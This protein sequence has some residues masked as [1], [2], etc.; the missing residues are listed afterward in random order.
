MVNRVDVDGSGR[1]V[2]TAGSAA[3]PARL[4]GLD[5]L[6]AVAALA[7][8]FHHV[9]FASG[10]TFD[11]PVGGLLARLDIG[12]PVFFALSGFLLFRPVAVSVIDGS[13]LRRVRDHLARRAL[14]IYPAFWVALLLITALTSESFRDLSAAATTAALV[15]IHW[16]GHVFGPMPQAWSLATEIAFYASLPVLARLIRPLVRA[17]GRSRSDRVVGLFACVAGL[18]L[19]SVFFRLWLH[20]LA[21]G[22][23]GA[24][25]LWLPSQIDYFAIGMGLAAA[26]AGWRPG[27]TGR[28]RLERWAAPA[29]WWWLAAA[30]LF[31]VT[32]E[33]LGLARGL[34]VANW[35]LE[36]LRQFCYGAVSFLLLFPLV[37]APR[38][39]PAAAR[40]APRSLVRRIASSR[41]LTGLGTISYSFYLWH[42]VFI[43]HPWPPARRAVD[44]VWD[45]TVRADW[46]DS[47]LGWTGAAGA[48][49]SRFA[50]LAAAALVPT[51]AVSAAS[52]FLV[53][54]AGLARARRISSPAAGAGPLESLVAGLR[55]QWREA[56]FRAQLAA[57]AVL[58]A[59][60]RFCYVLTA[61]RSETLDPDSVFPGDQFYYVLAGDALADGRGFVVPW[62]GVVGPAQEALAAPH[63]A[64]HP[65]L[66]ALAAALAGFLPGPPGSHVLEQRLTMAALGVVAVVLIGLLGRAVAGRAAGAAAAGLAAVHPG[67]WVNDG[68]VMSETLVAITTAGALWAAVRYRRAPSLRGMAELGAWLGAAVMTRSELALL[69]PL[70]VVPLVWACHRSRRRRLGRA[71]AAA[72]VAAALCA[73]WVTANLVRFSEPVLLS[74]N[75]GLTLA[76]ANNPQTYGGGAIGF[77]SL[78]HAQAVV[79]VSGLDQGEASAAYTEAAVE[80]ALD[81]SERWPA[82]LAARI[83]RVWS[84]YRPLQMADLNQGEG[85][86][87]WASLLALAGY[88]LLAPAAVWGWIV[89]RRRRAG[90][91]QA[92]AGHCG[93]PEPSPAGPCGAWLLAVPFVHVTLV[94]AAVYGLVRLRV[95]AEVALVVLA[96][97]AVTSFGSCRR[98]P[99]SS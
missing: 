59:A 7:V 67:L 49:D 62:R 44:F 8:F 16:P 35:P 4:A 77:W 58:A 24:A 34:A 92:A 45:A 9:G 91:R 83:G 38:A 5:G 19:F 89:L 11:S 31:A 40:S 93:A 20:G 18:Y 82:V 53:E 27:S 65:P 51:L 1:A 39:A 17:P 55:G 66:T 14:R 47:A 41:A 3:R 2:R 33:G 12:V 72:A 94:A 23:T 52:Y 85:R 95:P 71:L 25:L 15:H 50:V 90:S 61:K 86:E 56:T 30:A 46:F 88:G 26:R 73:P 97:V 76:G 96:G 32:A 63:A 6:R 98:A 75:V 42:M 79:D 54:R 74:S 84:L 21:A 70:I 81:N 22:W 87:V 48:V 13:P 68:L 28:A 43:V 64:D 69:G 36:M 57:I 80:Y 78:E 10:A 29:G 37:F 60:V 99:T